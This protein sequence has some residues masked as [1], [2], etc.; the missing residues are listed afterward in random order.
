MFG[1]MSGQ[2]EMRV[3]NQWHTPSWTAA[4]NNS[5]NKREISKV[6]TQA[7]SSLSVQWS[8]TPGKV[9]AELFQN[10]LLFIYFSVSFIPF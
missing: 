9:L 2:L 4:F 8:Y 1:R 10:K 3:G 5:S 7:W 6:P